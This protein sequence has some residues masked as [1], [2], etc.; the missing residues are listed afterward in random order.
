MLNRLN[1]KNIARATLSADLSADSSK[2]YVR[3]IEVFPEPPFLI[4]VDD[5]IMLVLSKT[6]IIY[7]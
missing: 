1:A 3:G 4:T 2:L 5:E 6:S 7:P